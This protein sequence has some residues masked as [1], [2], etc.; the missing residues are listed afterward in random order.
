ML[1]FELIFVLSNK[2]LVRDEVRRGL[3]L[4]HQGIL[5]MANGL[6]IS[7]TPPD[8]PNVKTPL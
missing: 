7:R 8:I 1:T 2:A 3:S 4:H 6:T 5:F